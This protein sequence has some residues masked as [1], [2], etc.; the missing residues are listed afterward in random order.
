MDLDNF[1]IIVPFPPESCLSGVWING[2]GDVPS[3]NETNW[4]SELWYRKMF[5]LV[6]EAERTVLHFEAV[7]HTAFVWVNGIFLGK[8][9]G[10]YDSFSFDITHATKSSDNEILVYTVDHSDY[11]VAVF[12]KQRVSAMTKPGGDTYTPSS[13]IW[14][15]VW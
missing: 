2:N 7:D 11:G 1:T 15:S 13:G 4:M 12:G 10:G 6:N 14:Q 3:D 8:H 9:V 5:D